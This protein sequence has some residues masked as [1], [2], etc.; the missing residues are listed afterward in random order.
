M[1][2]HPIEMRDPAELRPHPA[3]RHLHNLADDDARF[4]ALVD[5]MARDGFAADKPATITSDGS[6]LD[7]RHRWRAAKRL[8]L[9]RIPCVVRSDADAATVILE[10]IIA[11]KH[12]TKSALAFEC[13]PLFKAAHEEAK[14]RRLKKLRKGQQIPVSDSLRD[15]N[16]VVALAKEL[17]ISQDLFQDAAEVHKLFER[18]PAYAAQM[19]PRIFGE[20]VGG[21]HESTRPVGLGAVIAGHKGRAVDRG[22][23][24]AAGRRQLELFTKT[25][26][27]GITRWEYWEGLSDDAKADHWA[28][29]RAQASGLAPSRAEAMAHYYS[30]LAAEFR[31]AAKGQS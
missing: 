26:V 5:C 3:T 30:K 14:A 6:I 15:G 12:F 16:T 2:A 20:M 27:D 31:A 11:R 29:V 13:Y 21:E 24:P 25:V 4:L 23:K 1:T 22:G 18:D 8:Q 19:L 28:A 7:G 9:A 10:S 17:G